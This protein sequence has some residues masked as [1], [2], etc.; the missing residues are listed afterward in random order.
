MTWIT[1]A[2]ELCIVIA[3]AII[4]PPAAYYPVE[5]IE[6]GRLVLTCRMSG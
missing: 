5:Y 6:A 1:V 2:I 3:Y 4:E